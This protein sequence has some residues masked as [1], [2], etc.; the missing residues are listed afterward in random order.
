VN[1]KTAKRR[2]R[3]VKS[4]SGKSLTAKQARGVKGGGRIP[5]T[6]KWQPI[7]LKRGLTSE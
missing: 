3:G 7:T 6:L 4:L 2:T 1:K 5:G